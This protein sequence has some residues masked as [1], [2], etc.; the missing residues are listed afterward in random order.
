MVGIGRVPGS[1]GNDRN[2]ERS[3]EMRLAQQPT[4]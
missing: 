4:G 3:D 2:D 1:E